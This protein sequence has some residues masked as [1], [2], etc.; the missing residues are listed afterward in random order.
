MVDLNLSD[1]QVQ[2]VDWMKVTEYPLKIGSLRLALELA[3]ATIDCG[4]ARKLPK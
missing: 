3:F 1:P 2:R 4:T